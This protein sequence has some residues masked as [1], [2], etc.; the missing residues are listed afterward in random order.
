MCH[1]REGP[2]EP[3]VCDKS[4]L[5][6]LTAFQ[7]L[8]VRFPEMIGHGLQREGQE[9]QQT[10]CRKDPVDDADQPVGANINSLVGA[11]QA[12]QPVCV[13]RN[14]ENAFRPRFFRWVIA[15]AVAVPVLF[16]E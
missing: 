15:M 5:R 14:C 9:G 7:G 11:C 6:S 1:F 10:D 2:S 13:D 3:Q 8:V 12:F 4:R 16:D